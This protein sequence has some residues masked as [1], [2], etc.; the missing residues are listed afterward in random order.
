M[1]E[2]SYIDAT[3]AKPTPIGLLDNIDLQRVEDNK[4]TVSKY[5]PISRKSKRLFNIDFFR[6]III[7]KII[8]EHQLRKEQMVKNIISIDKNNKTKVNL[9]FLATMEVSLQSRPKTC[10]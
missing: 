3:S 1:L 10:V 6:D 8:L 7:K 5:S 9:S 2:L 4:Q